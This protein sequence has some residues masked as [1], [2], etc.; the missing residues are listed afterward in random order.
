MVW[1]YANLMRPARMIETRWEASRKFPVE[2]KKREKEIDKE[3]EYRFKKGMRISFP[4][5]ECEYHP[6][7]PTNPF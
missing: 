7:G 3:Y 6:V 2:F 1:L 4:E 5:K